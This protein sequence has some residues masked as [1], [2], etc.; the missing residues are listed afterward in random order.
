MV[1]WMLPLGLLI[2]FELVAD[3]FA[4]EWSL[5]QHAIWLAVFALVAYLIANTFWLFALKNGSGLA[6]G[7][8]IFSIASAGIAIILGYFIY[9][10]S[11]TPMQLTGL[12]FGIISLVLLLGEF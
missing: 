7:A 10:E 12:G 2:F 11:L 1:N 5:K 8:M 4:K 3:I 9:K 6:K